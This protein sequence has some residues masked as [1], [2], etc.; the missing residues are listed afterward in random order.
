[1]HKSPFEVYFLLFHQVLRMYIFLLFT[2]D[3]MDSQLLHDPMDPVF[4]VCG[5]VK[6]IDP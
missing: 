2:D 6:M 1:M 4:T 3:R 5:M